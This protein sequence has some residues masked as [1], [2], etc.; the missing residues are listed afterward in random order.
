MQTGKSTVERAIELARSSTCASVEDVRR[1]LKKE[2][3]EAVDSHISGASILKQLR[4]II[5]A[6][7]K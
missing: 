6:R 5:A 3:Y 2:H 1:A 4:E 7:A